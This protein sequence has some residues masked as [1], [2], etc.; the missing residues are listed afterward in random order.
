[1]ISGPLERSNLNEYT[2]ELSVSGN[3]RELGNNRLIQGA[4]PLN[5]GILQNDHTG[6]SLYNFY[7]CELKSDTFEHT[8]QVAS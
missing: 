8:P 4:W 5:G 7:I 2:V 3:T 6:H 1:M